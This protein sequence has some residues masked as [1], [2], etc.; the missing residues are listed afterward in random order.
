MLA[1]CDG[2]GSVHEGQPTSPDW[3]VLGLWHLQSKVLGAPPYN[4]EFS[5]MVYDELVMDP[6]P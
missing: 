2:V 3:D 4:Q 1:L 5:I 6:G